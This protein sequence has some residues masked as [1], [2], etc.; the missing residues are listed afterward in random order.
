M[1]AN[2]RALE[3]E[4]DNFTERIGRVICPQQGLLQPC[5]HAICSAPLLYPVKMLANTLQSHVTLWMLM[6]MMCVNAPFC[7]ALV[8]SL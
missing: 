5:I 1:L 6:S 2:C 3:R 8:G 7:L 4:M